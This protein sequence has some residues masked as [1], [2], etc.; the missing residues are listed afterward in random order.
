MAV[1]EFIQSERE[2]S[3]PRCA[4]SSHNERRLCVEPSIACSA[5]NRVQP[6]SAVW[7]RTSRPNTDKMKPHIN[8]MLVSYCTVTAKLSLQACLLR[9]WT[10]FTAYIRTVAV[11]PCSLRSRRSSL[12]MKTTRYLQCNYTAARSADLNA[13]V[14]LFLY[15]PFR[16]WG[17]NRAEMRRLFI[18]VRSLYL[19]QMRVEMLSP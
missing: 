12:G 3:R 7:N 10:E 16:I 19:A 13:A 4:V 9:R 6:T 2:T 1:A 8:I 11:G 5:W 17:A 15:L 18:E 14:V